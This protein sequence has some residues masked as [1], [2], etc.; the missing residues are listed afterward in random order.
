MNFL[1]IFAKKSKKNVN[2]WF[3]FWNLRPAKERKWSASMQFFFSLFRFCFLF[4]L[5]SLFPVFVLFWFQDSHLLDDNRRCIG[6]IA[7]ILF[8]RLDHD[9]FFQPWLKIEMCTYFILDTLKVFFIIWSFLEEKLIQRH[10]Q[11]KN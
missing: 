4:V 7:F 3:I 10:I 1:P 5:F 6:A 9:A 11:S 8:G 2:P